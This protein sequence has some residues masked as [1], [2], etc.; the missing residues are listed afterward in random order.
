MNNAALPA[1]QEAEELLSLADSQNPGVWVAHSK[2]VA[3]AAE[4]IASKCGMDKDTSYVLGLLHDIGRYEGKMG[5]RH[6]CTGF[7]LMNE[8][9]YAHNARIC[10]THAFPIKDTEGLLGDDCSKEE[11]EIIL[12]KINEYEFDDYD[13]LIQLCDAISM[14]EGICL[15]EVRLIEVTM[16]YKAY[17]PKTLEKWNALFEL[18]KYFDAKC[19]MNIYDLFYDEI[20]KNSVK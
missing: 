8:K 19:G 20:I 16:R 5:A 13:R 17:S 12:S 2:T 10:L 18:K 7:K 9:G 15:M 6:L 11:K 14:P 4:K 1:K 3:R